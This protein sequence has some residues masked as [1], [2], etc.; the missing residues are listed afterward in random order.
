[1]NYLL[2]PSRVFKGIN[3]NLDIYGSIHIMNTN[4]TTNSSTGSLIVDGG[5]GIS[6][7]LFVNG[8]Q[9]NYG[10]VNISNTTGT[11]STN[12]G[13]LIVGGGVGIAK[14]L[15]V[16]NHTFV[17]DFTV[18]GFSHSINTMESTTTDTGALIVDGGVGIAKNLNIGGN[19]NVAGTA[20]STTTS[21]GSL[22]VSGGVGIA[23]N[24]NVGG[25]L[26]VAG[27][28][29]GTI[30]LGTTQS[31][32]TSTGALI[33]GGGVGIGKNLNVGGSISQIGTGENYMT[34]IGGNDSDIGIKLSE[35][36][37]SYYGRIFYGSTTSQLTDGIN[38]A[39]NYT[40]T[41]YTGLGINDTM[42]KI[43]QTTASTSSNTGALQVLGGV[44][45]G[46]SV[47]IGDTSTSGTVMKVS[48]SSLN[49]YYGGTK[50]AQI[51]GRGTDSELGRNGGGGILTLVND[52]TYSSDVMNGCGS[53]IL[54]GRGS[55]NTI[56]N[57][58]RLTGGKQS[59]SLIGRFGIECQYNDGSSY[60]VMNM[61][62]DN[63]N[64]NGT[65]TATSIDAKQ[66]IYSYMPSM[67]NNGNYNIQN[68]SFW[69]GI[70]SLI[71]Y[72][73]NK[74]ISNAVIASATTS[75]T[76]WGVL[77]TSGNSVVARSTTQQTSSTGFIK[78]S[79][80][81][82]YTISALTQY[83]VWVCSFGAG[84]NTIQAY[85]QGGNSCN[86]TLQEMAN[87]TQSGFNV[88]N[89]KDWSNSTPTYVPWFMI[90]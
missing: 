90:Y 54:A 87:N 5:V 34:I 4:D 67:C 35:P 85:S 6:K 45:I 39:V 69:H 11:S 41:N 8:N 32:S 18:S 52:N 3:G 59:N 13:A 43:F 31:T 66:P 48:S 68:G 53:L 86:N 74:T 51:F 49:Y 33:V 57:F 83:Y 2:W 15:F 58:V 61:Y 76:I 72:P 22:I 9:T 79:F 44:G 89:P 40:G 80:S 78:L 30:N 1:M 17:N 47:N 46:K 75:T 88:Y 81:T 56:V 82:P 25:N 64:V 71:Y 24:L 20:Q 12:S 10:I 23:K 55:N 26:N 65:I 36:S 14:N 7:N 70:G 19:I 42:T 50:T 77:I 27:T 38:L 21:S 60:E 37:G 73:T 28:L 29:N 16:G 84:T 62:K 63:V